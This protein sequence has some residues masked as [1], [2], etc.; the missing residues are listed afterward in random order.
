MLR[1]L[2][3]F[4]ATY[5]RRSP[6]DSKL[7]QGG[8]VNGMA[9]TEWSWV[10]GNVARP[11]CWLMVD[12]PRVLGQ[13]TAV[14]RLLPRPSRQRW[15]CEHVLITFWASSQRAEPPFSLASFHG[16]LTTATLVSYKRTLNDHQSST[17]PFCS[18]LREKPA[19]N[20]LEELSAS[21]EKGI[22]KEI[23]YPRNGEDGP[24]NQ[25]VRLLDFLGE[26]I[27]LP[28]ELCGTREEFQKV[29]TFRYRNTA[30]QHY[31]ESGEYD[32]TTVSGDIIEASSWA[33]HV[34]PGVSIKL[35][36]IVCIPDAD[37]KMCPICS[38]T[39]TIVEDNC[40]GGKCTYCLTWSRFSNP[41]IEEATQPSKIS[42]A[43]MFYSDFYRLR[44]IRVI[45]ILPSRSQDTDMTN[46]VSASGGGALFSPCLLTN[47]LEF[48]IFV[49]VASSAQTL[50]ASRPDATDVP[51]TSTEN[52]HPTGREGYSWGAGSTDPRVAF[53]TYLQKT[54]LWQAVKWEFEQDGPL[55][56]LTHY[57]IRSDPILIR[58]GI[59]TI[60]GSASVFMNPVAL[61]MRRG[62]SP[63]VSNS[64][65]RRHPPSTPALSQTPSPSASLA[66]RIVPSNK[67]LPRVGRKTIMSPRSNNYE[68]LENGMGPSRFKGRTFSWKKLAIGAVVLIGLLSTAVPAHISSM[69]SGWKGPDPSQVDYDPLPPPTVPELERP[70]ADV[71]FPSSPQPPASRPTSYESD[72]DPLQTVHCSKPYKPSGPLVQYGLMIDA[73]STGSRIH[74]YKFHNCGP[75]PAYE[76]EVFKHTQPGLSSYSGAP[77]DAAASLDVL[78]DVAMATVPESLRKCTPVAVK[79][80]AGLRSLGTGQSAEILAAVRHRLR[81]AYPFPIAEQDGIVIMDG[82]DEGVYA[83]ITANYLMNTIRADSPKDSTPYAVLDLGGASTQIVFEPSFDK[84]KPDSYLHEGDHKYEL[85]FGGRTHVL[86]QHSYLGYGLMRA[87][88]SV[89]RLVDFA[90]SIRAKSAGPEIG[91]PCLARGTKRVVEIEDERAGKVRNVTM[92]GE[93]VGGF[94]ACNRVMQLVMA[95]DAIC[96]VKPCA[97]DGVYQP[98]ILDTFPA[99]KILLLSYFYDRLHPLLPSTNPPRLTISSLAELATDICMGRPAWEAR[100]GGNVAAM[101][102]LEGRPEYCLDLTFMHALLRLG[103]EFTDAREVQIGKQIDGTELGWALGAAIAMRELP[104][105]WA[106]A[107]ERSH[108]HGLFNE[109]SDEDFARAEEFC[110]MN[111]RN[112]VRLLPDETIKY[113]ESQRAGA[114]DLDWPTTPRFVGRFEKD[115]HT[116]GGVRVRTEH[117]CKDVC[118]FSNLPLVAGAYNRPQQKGVY[119]EVIVL[120]M[121]G[122]IAIVSN[123]AGTACKPYPNWRMPGWNRLSAGLHLDDL[124]KFFEDPDGGRDYTPDLPRIEEGHTVGCG[125]EF[126]TG[127]LFFT[128]NGVRLPDAFRGIYMPRHEHDVYAA[129]GVEGCN[130]LE[131]DFGSSRFAWEEGDNSAW[132]IEDQVGPDSAGEDLPSYN[133]ANLGVGHGG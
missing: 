53:N 14:G 75:S 26:P 74:V 50:T 41:S 103:Y 128:H 73:G 40:G 15:R 109:A 96:E 78:L 108:T 9:G 107:P 84:S 6:D 90:D 133:E 131:V 125:Y 3:F 28:V 39:G 54:G 100:W 106:P 56:Q 12:L 67:P 91:N 31:I 63:T 95:K 16:T 81:T 66:N 132:R 19:H 34:K 104:P 22:P 18:R 58:K 7:E 93:D 82:K 55:H 13:K 44:R 43:S 69:S 99:G 10:M 120:R 52:R 33:D 29:L 71:E 48:T 101:E 46:V 126:A 111:P 105:R 42:Q 83:W 76:Y 129:I 97:F 98:S 45:P 59:F 37:Q 11:F 27:I 88:K 57:A 121:E 86:Y 4:L 47:F 70:A 38:R 122:V 102:E 117:E 124:R 49:Y 115:F 118:L 114:W 25:P 51:S 77:Q 87:R 35:N 21:A 110:R 113:I 89:H 68:R 119:Y 20:M 23:E 1:S 94:E 60:C 65:F 61:I 36:A 130:E 116:I 5:W 127:S 85:I 32:V 72:P 112:P 2:F 64:L 79:A 123:T 24:E 92:V 8:F 17:K 30:G 80:T 62:G